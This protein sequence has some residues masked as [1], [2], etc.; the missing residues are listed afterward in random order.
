MPYRR[1]YERFI[2]NDSASVITKEGK[3]ER[4]LLKDLSVGG[5]G[6]TGN[7]SLDIN[8]IVAVVIKAPFFFGKPIYKQARVAWC[9]KVDTNLWESGLDF[10]LDKINLFLNS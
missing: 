3:E 4:L 1:M 5:A 8:E 2:L 6:V 10:G 7:A 9:E